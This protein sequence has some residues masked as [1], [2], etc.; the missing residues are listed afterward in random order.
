MY[1]YN[2]TSV[3]NQRAMNCSDFSILLLK[4]FNYLPIPM[5][6]F[7]YTNSELMQQH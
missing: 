3:K 2:D 4:K 7:T 1:N 5:N 6:Q